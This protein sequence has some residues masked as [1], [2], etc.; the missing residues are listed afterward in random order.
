[1]SQQN[2]GLGNTIVDG[3]Q[4]AESNGAGGNVID[5]NNPALKPAKD[6]DAKTK[7]TWK[8]KLIGWSVILLLIGAGVGALYLLMRVN[9]V[10]VMVNADSRRNTQS[11]RPQNELT[12][13]DSHLTGEAID[14][15]RS[16][17]GAD[18][19]RSHDQERGVFSRS[20]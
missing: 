8:R 16:A 12:N 19:K 9:R 5:P 13:S 18:A 10:N 20:C 6:P 11:T 17:A 14:M 1:M 15:V 7:K 2:K 4:G 3:E